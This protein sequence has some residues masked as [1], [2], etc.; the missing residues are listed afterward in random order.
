MRRLILLG[1][2][3]VLALAAV[4]LIYASDPLLVWAVE[5]QRAIQ[6]DLA[7]ALSDIRRGETAAIATL[8]GACITYGAVHA[9]GPGHG[10]LLIGGAAIASRRTARRMA[11]LGLAA[12]LAQGLTAVV[13]VYGGLGLI[14]VASRSMI[15]FSE[16]RLTAASY[17][18]I[19]LVGLWLLFRGARLSWRLAEPLLSET[20]V[21]GG[22]A[23]ALAT[24]SAH[25]DHHHHH[26]DHH[27]HAGHGC[28]AGCKHLPTVEE[29][30]RL[31]TWRDAL[32]LIVSIGIRPCSGALIVLALA[33]RYD[34][35]GVGVAA[36]FAMALGTGIFVAIVAVL[37]VSLRDVSPMRA[38][39]VVGLWSSA[40]TLVVVGFAVTVFSVTLAVSALERG[41]AP[42]PFANSRAT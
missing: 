40:V 5:Q 30:D 7:S 35:V 32:A 22:G 28:D 41:P 34:L 20:A 26:H 2:L 27:S 31:D 37:A 8:L 11:A 29:V 9:I 16:T 15:E 4:A 13:V 18:A 1:G 21:S 12:S 25:H 38:P 42:H 6:Q 24:T 36:A 39:G 10:K 3:A 33:W 14:S 23:P 19:A 17:G